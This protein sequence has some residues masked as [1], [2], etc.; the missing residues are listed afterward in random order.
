MNS[1]L[2]RSDE[3]V[4]LRG[5]E[6]SA[7]TLQMETIDVQKCAPEKS[8]WEHF[9]RWLID[10]FGSVFLHW[11]GWFALFTNIDKTTLHNSFF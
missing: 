10:H 3:R 5:V 11:S 6:T 1:M 9:T 4:W 8:V 7:S 2:R